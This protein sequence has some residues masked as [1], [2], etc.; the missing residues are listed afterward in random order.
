MENI[1]TVPQRR[2][3]HKKINFGE[4]AMACERDGIS[5]LAYPL[6]GDINIIRSRKSCT[7]WLNINGIYRLSHKFR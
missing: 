6:L 5:F 4:F 2:D 7:I 3:Y 1:Q